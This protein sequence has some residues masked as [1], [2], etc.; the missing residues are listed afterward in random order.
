MDIDFE[1]YRR[2]AVSRDPR[3]D[4][5]FFIAVTSTGIYCRPICPAQTPKPENVRF[6]RFAAAA[7]AAGFRACRRCRPDASPGSA[8]WNVRADLVARAL[9]LI[10]EGVVD[11]EGVEG[12][13]NRLAVSERHLHRQLVAEVGTGPLAL[14]RTRRAQTARVLVEQTA[15][16]LTEVAFAAG[17]SSIRQFNDSM[18]AAFGRTPTELRRRARRPASPPLDSSGVLTLRLAYR[19]P[20]DAPALLGFL[21]RRAV[22]GIEEVVGGRLRRVLS[23]PHSAAIAELE[24]L[25]RANQ[26]QLRLRLEDL[27]DL[28]VAVQRCRQ[29]LDLDAE[30]AAVAEVLGADPVLAPLVDAHPG[31]R[32]PGAVDGFEMAVRAIIGQRISVAGATTLTGRLVAALGEPLPNPDGGLTR[33][34]PTPERLAEADLDSLGV[35]SA[36]VTALRALASAVAKGDLELD[37]GADRA[38]ATAGLLALPGV[39]PWTVDYVAMRALGDPDAFPVTDLGLRHALLA[40]GLPADPAGITERAERWRPWRAY[41]I[42]HLWTSRRSTA[43]DKEFAA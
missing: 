36:R 39:G 16:P 26:V 21:G 31:L 5:H 23:L 4:G 3:F 10:A 29:L 11:A 19:P 30:P 41:A 34:F 22:A 27:R 12:L 35:T 37:R 28:G 13:A 43:P 24:P 18:R 2:A 8:E 14:A 32:V 9:R 38:S 40:H 42:L 20:L 15:L 6:Y 1:T 7:E 17:F 25:P 33:R